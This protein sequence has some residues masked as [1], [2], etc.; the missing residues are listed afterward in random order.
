MLVDIVEVAIDALEGW[1]G[2]ILNSGGTPSMGPSVTG[3]AGSS[4]SMPSSRPPGQ[5]ADPSQRVPGHRSDLDADTPHHD[6]PNYE[7]DLQDQNTLTTG[8]NLGSEVVQWKLG[9]NNLGKVLGPLAS[10]VA[11]TTATT[12]GVP[13][14]VEIDPNKWDTIGKTS[15]DYFG[16]LAGRE[17]GDQVPEPDASTEESSRPPAVEHTPENQEILDNIEMKNQMDRAAAR[18]RHERYS[19]MTRSHGRPW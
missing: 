1:F 8:A 5:K 6:D 19:G 3:S 18:R 4:S 9:F 11:A 13:L 7:R 16:D 10:I 14:V 15:G 17:S 12:E 2:S